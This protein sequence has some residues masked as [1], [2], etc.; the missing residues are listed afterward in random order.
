MLSTSFKMVAHEVRILKKM[1]I[2]YS[3]V[4]IMAILFLVRGKKISPTVLYSNQTE[5]AFG[6]ATVLLCSLKVPKRISLK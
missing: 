4:V 2:V 1:K 3:K 5:S 6:M